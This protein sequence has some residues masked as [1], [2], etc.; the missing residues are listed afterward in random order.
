MTVEAPPSS[1]SNNWDT[2]TIVDV[3][4][5]VITRLSLRAYTSILNEVRLS[6]EEVDYLAAP[7]SQPRLEWGVQ[8]V[9]TDQSELYATLAP[10]SL[11]AKRSLETVSASPIALIDGLQ[12]LHKQASIPDLF[13]ERTVHRV[14]RMAAPVA[15]GQVRDVTITNLNGHR[16]SAMV[17]E[18][19]L[20]HARGAV[21]PSAKSFGSIVGRLDVLNAR[22]RRSGK[23][24]GQI[25]REGTRS[26]VIIRAPKESA[27]TLKNAFG[28]RV[29]AYGQLTRNGV[30]QV[31]RLD[32]DE[33]HVLPPQ[34]RVSAR[35]I[36]GIAPNATGTLSTSEYIDLIRSG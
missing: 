9:R 11:P 13:N 28:S 27:D 14:Q 12:E 4:I 29:L 3:S 18:E 17:S 20:I 35:G 8:S 16:R 6:L 36:L 1:A 30:G 32:V 7:E 5:D 33:L 22:D 34:D 15:S 19:T 24:A 23:I 25:L 10:L 26:A 31:T 21:K 2:G